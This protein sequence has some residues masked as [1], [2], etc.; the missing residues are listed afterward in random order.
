MISRKQLVL[1]LF[2]VLLVGQ[3]SAA[4]TSLDIVNVFPDQDVR[5]SGT[6]GVIRLES[7]A[8]TTTTANLWLTK[9]D[10]T[11]VKVGTE[12]LTVKSGNPRETAFPIAGSTIDQYGEYTI[13]ANETNDGQNQS[14]TTTIAPVPEVSISIPE[15]IYPNEEVE[16][17]QIVVRTQSGRAIPGNE[18]VPGNATI[19][20]IN[21][22]P[23]TPGVEKTQ[24]DTVQLVYDNDTNN[25]E[26]SIP[27]NELDTGDYEIVGEFNISS[28]DQCKDFE[29]LSTSTFL[30]REGYDRLTYQDKWGS[31]TAKALNKNF[32]EQFTELE[33]DLSEIDDSISDI[34]EFG[35][36]VN[37][38]KDIISSGAT[39]ETPEFYYL[40]LIIALILIGVIV[41]ASL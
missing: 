10:G 15:R 8:T 2:A 3:A 13:K 22:D 29:S 32:D 34:D 37:S 4:I 21:D 14:L 33:E 16:D 12:D 7:D 5:E 41:K 31:Y 25:L 1:V 26:S 6:V 23:D 39:G 18:I 40:L 35:G 9:P 19:Y 30:I 24:V 27:I 20:D 38:A 11:T 28:C 17:V 36:Y